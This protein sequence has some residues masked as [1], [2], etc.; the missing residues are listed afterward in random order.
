MIL[1]CENLCFICVFLIVLSDFIVNQE[2]IMD[3]RKKYNS[4][5][6]CENF[7]N[8]REIFFN[9]LGRGGSTEHKGY[10]QDPITNSEIFPCHLIN[11]ISEEVPKSVHKLRPGDI[12]VIAAIG[13]SL[14]VGV[15][16]MATNIMGLT[17]ENRGFSF[18]IGGNWDW[19]NSSTLPNILKKFNP[20]I[21]G[22]SLSNLDHS[23][24]DSQLN[25]ADVNAISADLPAMSEILVKTMKDDP[26]IDFYNHWKM[27]TIMIGGNDLCTHICNYDKVENFPQKYKERLI[28]SLNYLRDNL[29]RTFVNIIPLPALQDIVLVDDKPERCQLLH[30][31]QCSCWAGNLYNATDEKRDLYREIQKQTW[32][33]EKDVTQMYRGNDNFTVIYQPFTEKF[34][35]SFY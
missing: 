35:V 7:H 22:Y 32:Q 14:T 9:V 21:I 17:I 1:N 26:R 2:F 29:P 31:M 12:A 6:I 20:N 18:S 34:S 27:L 24:T 11:T 19:R 16:A 3:S 15:G 28:K 4:P 13:D 5:A 33:V 8:I 10:L 30:V 25:I 23:F